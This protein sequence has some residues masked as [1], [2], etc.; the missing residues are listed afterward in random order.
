MP[1]SERSIFERFFIT[2]SE[3]TCRH[4][5]EELWKNRWKADGTE[6]SF[7]RG[8]DIGSCGWHIE[9]AAGCGRYT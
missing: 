2:M 4:P 6:E 7:C 1:T 3:R 9:P 5:T 8:S